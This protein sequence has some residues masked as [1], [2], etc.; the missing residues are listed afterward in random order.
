[1]R[2]YAVILLATLL[3]LPT[4]AALAGAGSGSS[5]GASGHQTSGRVEV[6][7][8]A[9]GWEVRLLDDF[10]FDGAPDPRIGFGASGKF[11]ADTDF[12]PLRS[13]DGAQVYKV[14]AGVDPADYDEVYIW[15]RKY[16]VPLGVAKLGD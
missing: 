11:A 1:M 15:C 12:E 10:V 3:V 8:T 9:D 13:N 4:G 5:S 7:K 2:K 14:P 16:S 6:V